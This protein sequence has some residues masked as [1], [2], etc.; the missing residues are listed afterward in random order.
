MSSY[1]FSVYSNQKEFLYGEGAYLYDSEQKEYIDFTSGIGVNCL[2]HADE[3]ILNA[4]NIQ[5][6]KLIHLSNLYLIQ[7]QQECAEKIANLSGFESMQCFFCNSGA[8]A[9]EAAIKLVRKYAYMHQ[10]KNHKIITLKNSFH[11]RTLTA[12]KA[13]GQLEKH[14]GFEPLSEE[15]IYANDI[16]DIYNKITTETVAVMLELVQGE[17][18]I[19]AWE[20]HEI[21]KLAYYLKQKEILLVVD[22]IQTGVYRIGEFLASNYYEIEPDVITLAKGLGGGLPIGVMMSNEKNIFTLGDHGST[23]GGNPLCTYVACRVLEKLD[24]IYRTQA[25][26]K[27]IHIFQNELVN[28]FRANQDIFSSYVGLGL[29][30]GLKLSNKHIL[31]QLLTIS[32]QNGLLVLRSGSDIV[33]FLPP[34]NISKEEIRKGFERFQTALNI[35]KENI[36][37]T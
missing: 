25:L 31:N 35:I 4:I 22:E 3:D 33:R 11:G 14:K 7:A 2:G 12:L 5:A 19:N 17:G 37:E 26:K 9:N 8:E 15:F 10:I 27:T 28:C 34:L 23:F 18:G 24:E 21:Q 20:K 32:E 16:K 6:Q 30:L 1:L 36:Y 13:T 29:M